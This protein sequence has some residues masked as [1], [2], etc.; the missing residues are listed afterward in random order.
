MKIVLVLFVLISSLWAA[1]ID[2]FAQETSYYRNYYT[3]LDVAKKENKVI[4]LVLVA[5]FCPWCKKFERKSLQNEE[6]NKLVKKD[7][8]PVIVDNY[9][10]KDLYPSE[11]YTKRLP[12]IYF[13]NPKSGHVFNKSSLYVKKDDFIISIKEALI[14][15]KEDPQ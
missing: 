15:L 5:D 11:L 4:M 12:A 1:R 3:A 9:R 7:F 10:D 6:V 8:I 14:L 2:E 13:I